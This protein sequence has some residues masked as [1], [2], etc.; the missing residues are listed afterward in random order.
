M[1]THR[2]H[3][4]SAMA[5]KHPNADEHLLSSAPTITSEYATRYAKGAAA[6]WRHSVW[7]VIAWHS[8]NTLLRP[9]RRTVKP[10]ARTVSWKVGAARR[11]V[12]FM[13]QSAKHHMQLNL[14]GTLRTLTSRRSRH[15]LLFGAGSGSPH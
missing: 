7:P 8:K 10:L 6:S 2:P 14:Q 4:L 3:K 15:K 11:K 5:H 9:L 1:T 13:S 12:C